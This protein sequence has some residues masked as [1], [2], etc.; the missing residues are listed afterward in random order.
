MWITTALVV[1]LTVYLFRSGFWLLGVV[2]FLL[3]ADFLFG[4]IR[5]TR[6]EPPGGEADGTPGEMP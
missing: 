3:A 6:G 1:G 2:A 4:S 5:R